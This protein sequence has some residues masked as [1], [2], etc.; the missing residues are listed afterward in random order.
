MG[1]RGDATNA[2][3]SRKKLVTVIAKVGLDHQDFLGNDIEDIAKEKC[4]IFANNINIIFDE[5]NLSTVLR[6]IRQEAQ[7]A[8]AYPAYPWS[9]SSFLS[10]PINDAFAGDNVSK[11][12]R[13]TPLY[14]IPYQL[15]NAELAFRA[16]YTFIDQYYANSNDSDREQRKTT[17]AWT[18]L[19]TIART[20]IPGRFQT[21][22]LEPLFGLVRPI[23]L[24]GAHN[25]QAIKAV[26]PA[27]ANLRAQWPSG[28]VTWIVAF[29]KG[30]ALDEMLGPI[31]QPNDTVIA[32][33]FG[34]VDGMP[35]KRAM[36]SAEI[37]SCC[38]D[39]RNLGLEIKAKDFGRDIYGALKYASSAVGVPIVGIGSLYLVSDILRLLEEA[40]TQKSYT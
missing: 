1:G 23:T 21:V 19:E 30:K 8:N 24:D 22:D 35:W 32:V 5:T 12:L 36:S 18:M 7:K 39:L 11:Y 34:P 40:T 10:G 2:F 9:K 37:I 33:E 14:A 15:I 25:S 16:A 4:G 31:L 38:D 3:P 13:N 28:R 20:S 29:S 17:V 6:V 26:A 27:L